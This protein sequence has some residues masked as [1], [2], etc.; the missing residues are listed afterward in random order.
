MIVGTHGVYLDLNVGVK[1]TGATG[2]EMV[3]VSPNGKRVV[4]VAS[5]QDEA[6]GIIRYITEKNVF[7]LVGDYEIQAWVY[8]GTS[9]LLKSIAITLEITESL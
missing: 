2:A 9:R 7:N 4:G 6:K 1:L 3:I 5:V 8:F